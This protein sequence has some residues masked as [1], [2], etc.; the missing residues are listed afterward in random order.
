MFF[1]IL[2]PKLVSIFCKPS[3][4]IPDAYLD[5][6]YQFLY[7]NL[8]RVILVCARLQPYLDILVRCF[9]N[10]P[11]LHA[12]VFSEFYSC[13]SVSGHTE[14]RFSLQKQKHINRNSQMDGIKT[15]ILMPNTIHSTTYILYICN[16][17]NR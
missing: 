10:R 13:L 1:W 17:Y 12:G 7:S 11:A 16:M 4:P 15:R 5:Y 6:K 8:L 3:R 9:Q 2:K 14:P